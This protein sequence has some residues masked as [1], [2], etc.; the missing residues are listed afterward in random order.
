MRATS[1]GLAPCRRLGRNHAHVRQ[2][3][4]L[5]SRPSGESTGASTKSGA[6]SASARHADA[7]AYS[8]DENLEELKK[9]RD[10]GW[11]GD[12]ARPTWP[13]EV[14]E[15]IRRFIESGDVMEAV[16]LRSIDT[17]SL[18]TV[19]VVDVVYEHPIYS[20]RNPIGLRLRVDEPPLGGAFFIGSGETV[21]ERFADFVSYVLIGE[22][23]GTSQLSYV[24]DDAGVWWHAYGFTEPVAEEG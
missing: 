11:D 2:R 3:V 23:P 15:C 5:G 9:W 20:R 17:A 19:P 16:T 8:E 22:P 12:A 24:R 6:R 18:G 13:H 1:S 21:L 7:V 4:R 14:A 10:L